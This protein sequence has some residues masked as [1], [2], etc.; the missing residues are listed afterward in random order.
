MFAR[1]LRKKFKANTPIFTEE[2]LETFKEYSRPRIFQLLNESLDNGSIIKYDYGVYYI[3]NRN[4]LGIS[5]IS[6][7]QV[8]EK[9]YLCNKKKIYGFLGKSYIYKLF[10]LSYG[11]E[12]IEIITNNESSIKRI[13]CIKNR[14]VILH[15]SR[16]KITNQNINVY[17]LLELLTEFDIK[18]YNNDLEFRNKVH[19]F[20]KTKK[21]TKNK[22]TNMMKYFPKKTLKNYLESGLVDFRY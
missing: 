19:E 1:V 22:I 3:P 6:F 14:N 21:I 13:V 17:L 11:D 2:I 12:V 9:K 20:I 4:E 15:K 10:G 16:C 18:K 5:S 7:D 8:I